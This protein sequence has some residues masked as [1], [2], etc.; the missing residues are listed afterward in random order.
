MTAATFCSGVGAPEVAGK[1]FY[2]FLYSCEY[3][4]LPSEVLKLRFP[5]VPNLGDM[6]AVQ[7]NEIYKNSNP[8][9]MIAG[10]PCQGFSISGLK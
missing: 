3:E 8:E 2:D 5:N 10:T 6:L 7:Q 4:K 1:D 9:I